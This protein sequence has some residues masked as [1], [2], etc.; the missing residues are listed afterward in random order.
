MGTSRIKKDN[1]HRGTKLIDLN[2]ATERTFY[3]RSAWQLIAVQIAAC[4]CYRLS[5]HCSDAKRGVAH[6]W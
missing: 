6:N 5:I 2:H 1:F 3:P 4:H